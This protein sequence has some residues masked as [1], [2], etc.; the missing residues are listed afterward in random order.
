VDLTAALNRRYASILVVNPASFRVY[1]S[2]I[3]GRR[4]GQV[5]WSVAAAPGFG[6]SPRTRLR[7]CALSTYRHDFT[8]SGSTQLGLDCALSLPGCRHSGGR[9]MARRCSRAAVRTMPPAARVPVLSPEPTSSSA[10]Y[11]VQECWG[12][13]ANVG[14]LGADMF[15]CLRSATQRTRL[16]PASRLRELHMW[17]RHRLRPLASQATPP[18]KF[19]TVALAVRKCQE[20]PGGGPRAHP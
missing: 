17:E 15:S 4:D 8:C 18:A 14:G 12:W 20:N 16:S 13:A 3:V 7:T 5:N 10:R 2:R 19:S 1:S 11:V 6:S 9:H